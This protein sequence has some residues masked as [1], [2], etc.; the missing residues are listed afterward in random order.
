MKYSVVTFLLLMTS[1]HAASFD[2]AKATSKVE[3]LICKDPVLSSLDEELGR[4]YQQALSNSDNST[5]QIARQKQWLRDARN[6]CGDVTCL[7]LLYPNRIYELSI[8]GTYNHT[9]T[10]CEKVNTEADKI[11]WG[12]CQ[13][14]ISTVTIEESGEKHYDFQVEGELIFS[15][16]HQCNFKSRSAQ[17]IGDRLTA[18]SDEAVNCHL[19]IF[20]FGGALHTV[21]SGDCSLLCGTRGSLDGVVLEKVKGPQLKY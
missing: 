7:K 19:T 9:D 8:A 1:A 18:S 15:N 4:M 3:K 6:K 17:W 5:Q 14:T 10:I 11:E 20:F 13:K 16:W 12:N 21:A 2:C